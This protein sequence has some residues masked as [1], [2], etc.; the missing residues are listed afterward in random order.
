MSPLEQLFRFE[1]EFHRRLREASEPPAATAAAHTSFA[2]RNGYEALLRASN[3]AT[4]HDIE[5]V[6]TRL[7][8]A[9]DAR[10]SVKQLLGISPLE[11]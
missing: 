10:D 1:V 8:S 6:K 2:L 3:E 4:G 7:I 9:G 5:T 11:V